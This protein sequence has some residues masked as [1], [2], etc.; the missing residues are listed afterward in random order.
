MIYCKD[1]T[2]PV[3]PLADYTILAQEGAQPEIWFADPAQVSGDFTNWLDQQDLV[4]TYPPLI[5]YTPA[6]QQCGIHIDGYAIS[7]RASMN[8]VLKGCGSMMHWYKLNDSTTATDQVITQAGTPYTLC[9]PEQVTHVHSAVVAWPSLVQ[10]GVPHNIHNHTK[11]AR[12]CIS[13]DISRKN[14]NTG[15]TMTEAMEVFSKWM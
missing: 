2:I 6:G 11:E 10:I 4:M 14:S 7:D 8:F 15:L 1:L 12:W 5:F 3:G 13:C 9:E